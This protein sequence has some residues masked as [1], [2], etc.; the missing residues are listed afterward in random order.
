MNKVTR[1]MIMWAFDGL[2]QGISAVQSAIADLDN[3]GMDVISIHIDNTRR[4][5]HEVVVHVYDSDRFIEFFPNYRTTPREPNEY[6]HSHLLT[7]E[8][9]GIK[10]INLLPV[11]K[12]VV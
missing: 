7:A 10:I 6:G 12:E 5:V 9:N 1:S 3:C 4:E 2:I 11:K 8:M